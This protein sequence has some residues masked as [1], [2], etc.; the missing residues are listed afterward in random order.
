[1][2]VM[3]E[4]LVIG[5]TDGTVGIFGARTLPAGT[6]VGGE[7]RRLRVVGQAPVK[8]PSPRLTTPEWEGWRRTLEAQ[9]YQLEL[10]PFWR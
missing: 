1:M 6:I 4:F 5:S 7:A 2:E 9:G 10:G 3:Q 8:P